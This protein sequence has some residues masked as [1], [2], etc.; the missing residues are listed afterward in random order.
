MSKPHEMLSI[1]FMPSLRLKRATRN[2]VSQFS[3]AAGEQI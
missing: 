1:A 2:R 3:E